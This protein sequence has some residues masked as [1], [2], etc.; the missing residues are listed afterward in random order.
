MNRG[1]YVTPDGA[2]DSGIAVVAPT[3]RVAKKIAYD[4]GEIVFGDTRWIALRCR[5]CRGADV[6]GLGVGVVTD[7]RDALIRGLYGGLREFPCD[8]CGTEDDYVQ[9]Y[10]GRVLCGDCIE[11]EHAVVD[12]GT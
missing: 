2:D 6:V 12:G 4:S 7:A 3:A 9:C 1:Y 10:N 11:K 8:E 5:W